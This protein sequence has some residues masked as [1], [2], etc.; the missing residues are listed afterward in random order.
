MTPRFDIAAPGDFTRPEQAN[1]GYKGFTGIV[2]PEMDAFLDVLAE[3]IADQR[4]RE[5]QDRVL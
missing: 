1:I 2:D 3:L 4:L 5:V